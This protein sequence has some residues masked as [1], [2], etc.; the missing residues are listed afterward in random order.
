MVKKSLLSFLGVML[1]ACSSMLFAAYTDVFETKTYHI[2]INVLCP[3]GNVSC[4]NVI[5][6]G[7][8][9]K[10]NASITLKGT[11]LN[12]DCNTG[13][14]DFYGYEFKNKDVTYTIYQYGSLEISKKGEVIFSED[15]ISKE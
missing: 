3:E 1:L 8:R 12:K 11:T 9:K 10:D 13:T 14:C 4:D 15:R 7:V 5:Y 2:T 6:T